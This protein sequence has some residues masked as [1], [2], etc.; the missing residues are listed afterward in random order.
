[1][2]LVID[3]SIIYCGEYRMQESSSLDGAKLTAEL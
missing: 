3:I 2:H 1:M